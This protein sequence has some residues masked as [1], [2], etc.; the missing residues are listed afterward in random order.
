MTTLC[1]W[2]FGSWRKEKKPFIRFY[3][4]TPGVA[5]LFPVIRSSSLDRNFKNTHEHPDVPATKNCPAINKITNSGWIVTAPA[6]FKIK[7]NGDGVSIEWLEPYQFNKSSDHSPSSYVVLHGRLQ[8]E[9]IVDDPE[10]TVK[11]VIKLETPWRIDA[12]EDIVLIQMPVTYSN[13]SRFTAAIGILDPRYGH[14]VN[15]QLFWKVMN[16]ETIVRAGT[17]LCQFVPIPRDALSTSSYDVTIDN[18]TDTDIQKER[19][20]NYASNCVFLQHDKLSSRLQRVTTIL[21]KYKTR[22]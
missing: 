18:A 13:E 12:S 22:R 14:T 10:T 21:N 16:G 6:D 11:T 20:F 19:E 1:K 17:P 8:T 5:Q 7:T 2:L 9:P 15:V 4:L 3:S